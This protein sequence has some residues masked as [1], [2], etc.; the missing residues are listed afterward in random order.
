[1]KD[2]QPVVTDL[3]VALAGTALPVEQDTRSAVAPESVHIDN[4]ECTVAL[5]G[6][7]YSDRVPMVV[8]KFVRAKEILPARFPAGSVVASHWEDP[9]R[10]IVSV[11]VWRPGPNHVGVKERNQGFGILPIPGRGFPI[12]HRLNRVFFGSADYHH[13]VEYRLTPNHVR[14]AARSR[15]GRRERRTEVTGRKVDSWA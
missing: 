4:R 13:R 3:G 5:F 1:M 10:R 11:A 7:D 9:L 12:D 14:G 8:N 15:R 2:E 6:Q